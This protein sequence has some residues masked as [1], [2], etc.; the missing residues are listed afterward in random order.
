[1]NHAQ[2]RKIYIQGLQALHTADRIG[3][4]LARVLED[5][6]TDD[7]LRRLLRDGAES[8]QRDAERSAALL[9]KTGAEPGS[10]PDEIMDG[11]RTAAQRTIAATTDN[12]AQDAGIIAM[13]R[14]ALL[15][16]V[17]SYSSIGAYAKAMGDDEASAT[18]DGMVRANQEAFE[19]YNHLMAD[20]VRLQT[21]DGEA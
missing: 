7:R 13:A 6:A 10:E 4:D 9:K 3:R 17:S 12:G 11:V 8:S 14:I 19:R 2:L 21:S 18:L 16:Y 20:V 15:Y 5:A 1:M